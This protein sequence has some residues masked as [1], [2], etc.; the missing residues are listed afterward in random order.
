MLFGLV[1]HRRRSLPARKEEEEGTEKRA[2]LGS[3]ENSDLCLSFVGCCLCL[4]VGERPFLAEEEEK[5]EADPATPLFH[6]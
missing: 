6:Y 5:R 2:D 4:Q 3:E 1:G